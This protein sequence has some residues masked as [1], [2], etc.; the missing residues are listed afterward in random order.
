MSPTEVLI[1]AVHDGEIWLLA[2]WISDEK[3]TPALAGVFSQAV[4][5]KFDLLRVAQTKHSTAL[6]ISLA[7]QNYIIAAR[8]GNVRYYATS[9]FTAAL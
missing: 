6:N 7:P 1:L 9:L 5:G 8:S 3:K 4:F 2:S